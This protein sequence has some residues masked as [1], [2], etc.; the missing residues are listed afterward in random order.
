MTGAQAPL[1]AEKPLEISAE[2]EP[3]GTDG[4][5]VAQGRQGQG[6]ALY[7]TGGKLAFA[8]REKK[9]LT[10]IVAKEP[11]GSGHFVVQASLHADGSMA[12]VVDGKQVAE[13]KAGGLI[14]RATQER[15]LRWER[16]ARGGG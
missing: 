14:P 13:G 15:D 8:V 4:V 3:A 2:I 5:I 16:P 7:L 9:E 12:L 6:Y 10:T 11:L 1:V